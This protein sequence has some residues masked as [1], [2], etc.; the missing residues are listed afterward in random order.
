MKSRSKINQGWPDPGP[1]SEFFLNF[2][3]PTDSRSQEFREIESF[4]NDL[5]EPALSYV[6]SANNIDL[7][8]QSMNFI[9]I[10]K[11]ESRQRNDEK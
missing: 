1:I 3:K 8:T 5:I 4:L 7:E 2:F 10:D 11:F 6:S 9:P